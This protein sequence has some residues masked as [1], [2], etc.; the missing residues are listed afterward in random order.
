MMISFS[1]ARALMTAISASDGRLRA[2]GETS[3]F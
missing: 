2:E 3:A 1:A